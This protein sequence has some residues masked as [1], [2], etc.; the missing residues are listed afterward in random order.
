MII[1][2]TDASSGLGFWAELIQDIFACMANVKIPFGGGNVSIFTIAITVV[3]VNLFI[4]VLKTVLGTQ[5]DS[6]YS[7]YTKY[8]A[9]RNK[10]QSQQ[11]TKQSKGG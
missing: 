8:K 5:V 6:G 10:T 9:D 3:L 4:I 2:S 11:K 1:L 7:R